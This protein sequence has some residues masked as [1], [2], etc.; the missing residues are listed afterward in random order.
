MTKLKLI[1]VKNEVVDG[2]DILHTRYVDRP[3]VCKECKKEKR[4]HSSSRCL[5]CGNAF[6]VRQFNDERVEQRKAEFIKNNN[7]V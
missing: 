1:G 2:R 4:Q 5:G 3:A 7:V 6:R